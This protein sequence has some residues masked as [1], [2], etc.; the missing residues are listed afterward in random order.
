MP[1]QYVFFIS[2]VHFPFYVINPPKYTKLVTCSNSIFSRFI[3]M[4]Q[5]FFPTAITL[6]FCFS[7]PNLLL[8]SFT[9]SVILVDLLSFLLLSRCHLQIVNYLQLFVHSYVL[10]LPTSFELF[11]ACH[12]LYGRPYCNDAKEGVGAITPSKLNR[13]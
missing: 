7:S 1:I 3:F 6:V 2:I 5:R 12:I 10:Q 13:G 11:M 8:L 4:L 9:L